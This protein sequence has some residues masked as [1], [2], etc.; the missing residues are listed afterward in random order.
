[1]ERK[2]DLGLTLDI[3]E[4]LTLESRIV[5]GSIAEILFQQPILK[6]KP[7]YQKKDTI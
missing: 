6:R 7:K 3:E 4:L 1:M 5:G 2:M